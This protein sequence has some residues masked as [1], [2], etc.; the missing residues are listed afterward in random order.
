MQSPCPISNTSVLSPGREEVKKQQSNASH[1]EHDDKVVA[2]RSGALEYHFQR[3][4]RMQGGLP[5]CGGSPGSLFHWNLKCWIVS[6][7]TGLM[8]ERLINI[9]IPFTLTAIGIHIFQEENNFRT[10]QFMNQGLE[11]DRHPENSNT[12]GS[13]SVTSPRRISDRT[14]YPIMALG[15]TRESNNCLS[16]TDIPLGSTPFTC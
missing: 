11:K 2:A 1:C 13:P 16:I 12:V 15:L 5:S 14:A 9:P 4:D 8:W 3:I 6:L 10:I 7:L